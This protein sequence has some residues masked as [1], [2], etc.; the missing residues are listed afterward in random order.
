MDW[1]F[2]IR[3]LA[4]ILADSAPLVL[5]SVGETLTE[6]VG[7]IN[8][9][10]DGSILLSAMA[11]FAVAYLSGSLLIGFAVAM[12]VGATVAL[13]IA[14]ASI[15]LRLDQV[16]VGFVLTLL[17][18][19]LSSFL[20]NPFVRKPGP[21]VAPLP[22]PGLSTI[23]A[24]GPLFF[25]Q[26]VVVYGSFLAIILSW[27]WIFRTRPG[28]EMQSVGER[29]EAAFARGIN[30]NRLRYLYTIVG[31]ALV[32][33]AGAGY[34]LNVKPGWS[35]NLTLGIGWIAL[36]IVIFG[37]WNPLRAALGAYLFGGLQ[38]LGSILQGVLPGVPTQIFQAAPFAMMIVVLVLVR[39]EAVE[40]ALER[41]PGRAG[42]AL[43]SL[44][45]VTPPGALGTRF[46]QE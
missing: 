34:S 14:V 39:S 1:A 40:V 28:L 22:I 17:A 45:R 16:A 13:I 19:D 43:A 12:I 27:I 29:P 18:A 8:L 6:K 21:T 46:E 37:G 10:L 11:G 24:L 15:H 44:L 35:Y 42:T 4:A 30:V 41:L 5:A 23:P 33:L 25:S 31:G 2:L 3:I 32:G 7:V 38:S 36:A 9:S 20:G 26:N